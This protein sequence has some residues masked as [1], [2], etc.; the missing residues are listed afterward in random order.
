MEAK[1]NKPMQLAHMKYTF[2][3]RKI[4]AKQLRTQ[5]NLKSRRILTSSLQRHLDEADQSDYRKKQYIP[6]KLVV[7]Q[8]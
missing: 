3:W 4:K 8:S 7:N 1:T 5:V 2:F 6:R